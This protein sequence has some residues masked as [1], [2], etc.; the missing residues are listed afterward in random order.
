M[1]KGPGA[2]PPPNLHLKEDT[3]K[4]DV[5][6][7]GLSKECLHHLWAKPLPGPAT[8]MFKGKLGNHRPTQK[9]CKAYA[10]FA[11]TIT[12]LRP[13]LPHLLMAGYLRGS[14]TLSLI[15]L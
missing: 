10:R 9:C 4:H 8:G 14:L 13:N 6:N 3:A 7:P 11:D 12:E 1:M 5:S 15:V 2:P